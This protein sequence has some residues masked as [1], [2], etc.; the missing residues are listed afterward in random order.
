MSL[1]PPWFFLVQETPQRWCQSWEGSKGAGESNVGGFGLDQADVKDTSNGREWCAHVCV[2]QT[3]AGGRKARFAWSNCRAWLTLKGAIPTLY[4]WNS[5][6]FQ[7]QS[8]DAKNITVNTLRVL[9]E[10][11]IF[12]DHLIHLMDSQVFLRKSEADPW[13]KIAILQDS[14][15][16]PEEVQPTKQWFRIRMLEV[17]QDEC[18]SQSDFVD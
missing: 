3:A 11:R 8:K 16:V 15:E 18:Q 7:S 1:K 4:C 13:R 10:V 9:E 12:H 5:S 2:A 14:A 6:D 17:F